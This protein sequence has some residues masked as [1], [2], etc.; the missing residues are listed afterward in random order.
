M[1]KKFIEFIEAAAIIV[2]TA[3]LV[4]G[5]INYVKTTEH[6]DETPV[7]EED[8]TPTFTL[9]TGAEEITLE[10]EEGTTW[11]DWFNSSYNTVF[12]YSEGNAAWIMRINGD[13]Y[14]ISDVDLS[15]YIISNH[16]YELVSLM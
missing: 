12:N 5:V 4:V 10:F 14:G 1:A 16:N 11:E 2:L 13:E 3:V 7:V 6:N 9:I 15:D 8:V